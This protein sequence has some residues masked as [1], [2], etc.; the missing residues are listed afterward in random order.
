MSVLAKHS[1][2]CG[3]GACAKVCPKGCIEMKPDK[4]GFLYPEIDMSQ[5]VNCGRCT[6]ACMG[7]EP[8]K[9][10]TEVLATYGIQHKDK[11]T[12]M[13][14]TS[15][16]AFSALAEYVIT[17]GGVVFGGELGDFKVF[18]SVAEDICTVA[19]FRGS[20]YVQSDTRNTFKEAEDYLK[21]GV[22][23]LYSGTPC[24]IQGLKKYLGKEYD[25]LYTVD[26]ICHAAPSPMLFDKYIELQSKRYGKI[27]NFKFRDKSFGYDN[28]VLSFD[29]TDSKGR[30]RHYAKGSE[31]DEWMRLFLS[32]DANRESCKDCIAQTGIYQSDITIAD[33]FN[34]SALAPEMDNNKGC[35]RLLV[36]S[37]KGEQ[38][39]DAI[40][41]RVNCKE[42]DL[43]NKKKVRGASSGGKKSTDVYWD[44]ANNMSAEA[45][46][47]KYYGQTMKI[48]IKR[49]VRLVAYRTGLYSVMKKT[50]KKLRSR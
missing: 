37:K 50:V 32:N 19:K 4:T 10:N 46:F 24:Q 49:A 39:L 5:C 7:V 31:S 13:E 2:C 1:D 28:S 38:L 25:N 35:T 21:Q 6:R 22:T 42:V 34:V 20:K 40:K 26:V 23:V 17:Q 47:N 43:G 8:V 29:Y 41:D 44:D 3:C 30:K 18:Q 14:S 12:L 15:G 27:S 16:G 45:F 33:L 48:K 9:E 11:E 36:Q